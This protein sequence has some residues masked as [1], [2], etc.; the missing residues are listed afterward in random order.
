MLHYTCN[1]RLRD[2]YSTEPGFLEK[3][4]A[5]PGHADFPSVLER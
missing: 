4:D 1:A 2:S 5:I 3:S